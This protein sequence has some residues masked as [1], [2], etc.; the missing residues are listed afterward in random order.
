MDLFIH[1]GL[2]WPKV[3]CGRLTNPS[4]CCFKIYCVL[5]E[6]LHMKGVRTPLLQLALPTY[7]LL[8]MKSTINTSGTI[9]RV[10]V[11][12]LLR[13]LFTFNVLYSYK[14]IKSPCRPL[15]G[16]QLGNIDSTDYQRRYK[17]HHGGYKN[18]AFWKWEFHSHSY[19]GKIP[20]A[21]F[22]FL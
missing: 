9:Y 3:H 18:L 12:H 21:N 22:Y 10:T 7:F 15:L 4:I 17:N 16:W 20:T 5:L 19:S 11:H 14:N 6:H 13:S 2:L 8:S 1:C